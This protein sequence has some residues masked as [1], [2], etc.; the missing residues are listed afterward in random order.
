METATATLY[1]P[2]QEDF[3]KKKNIHA[4]RLGR[5]GGLARARKLSKEEMSKIGKMGAKFGI[6]GGRPKKKKEKT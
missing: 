5:L 4:V 6:L 3:M 1:S 2:Q